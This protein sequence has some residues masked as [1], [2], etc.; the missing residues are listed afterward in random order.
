MAAHARWAF[1]AAAAA[2][3]L[4][5]ASCSRP[6]HRVGTRLDTVAAAERPRAAGTEVLA[7]ADPANSIDPSDPTAPQEAPILSTRRDERTLS[8][9]HPYRDRHGLADCEIDCSVHEAGYKWAALHSLSDARLCVGRERAFVA[10][11]R[12]YVGDHRG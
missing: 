3:A 10:G 11:C 12:A 8:E 7:M 5:L 9:D 1:R 2:L 4:A 6:T